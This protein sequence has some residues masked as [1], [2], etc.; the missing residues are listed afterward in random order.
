MRATSSGGKV[1]VWY[2]SGGGGGVFYFSRLKHL[3]TREFEFDSDPISMPEI[4]L[5]TITN[6][7]NLFPRKPES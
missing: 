6:N 7:P 5:H 4:R 3:F 1:W 2:R